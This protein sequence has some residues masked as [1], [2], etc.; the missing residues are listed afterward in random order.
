M[1]HINLNDKIVACTQCPRLVEHLHNSAESPPARFRGQTYHARPVPNFLPSKPS[2]IRILM[3]GLAPGAHG[4]NR[5]GRMFTGDR[6]GGFLFEAMHA[7]GLCNQPEA[8]SLD[9]GLKLKHIAITAAAHCAP[10]GNKPTR[11]ELEACTG[12]LDQTF[13]ACSQIHAVIALGKIAHDAVLKRYKCLGAAQ[14]LSQAPFGHGALHRFDSPNAPTLID[15]FHPSQQNTFTKKL[16]QP[17]LQ[18]VLKLAMREA[19]VA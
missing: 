18:D 4:A 1:N 12:F 10:P 5:T 3:V 14:S 17:M 19:G 11:D 8:V 13:E 9:D 7:V 15:C 16:T 2:T 6:S